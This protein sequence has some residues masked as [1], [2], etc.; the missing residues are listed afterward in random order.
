MPHSP[1]MRSVL[2]PLPNLVKEGPQ[3]RR[4]ALLARVRARSSALAGL[5]D[6]DRKKRE[7]ALAAVT[8]NGIALQWAPDRFKNDKEVVLAAVASAGQALKYVGKALQAD[9]DVVSAAVQQNGLALHFA[10]PRLRRDKE[11]VLEAC[12]RDGAALLFADDQLRKDEDCKDIAMAAHSI[13]AS[14][15][16][17]SSRSSRERSRFVA[18]T[19]DGRWPSLLHWSYHPFLAASNARAVG[20]SEAARRRS[21]RAGQTFSGWQGLS[22][23]L[24]Q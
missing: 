3:V 14:T 15:S 16:V 19:R 11:L 5:D 4:A 24:T 12:Q 18:S 22:R 10:S 2:P 23:E 13:S 7:V 8:A 21:M 20:D 17:R 9:R 6:L 1:A